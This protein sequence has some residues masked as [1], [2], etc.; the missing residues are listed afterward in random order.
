MTCSLTRYLLCVRCCVCDAA[1]AAARSGPLTPHGQAQSRTV[2]GAPIGRCMC[3]HA[4]RGVEKVGELSPA[5]RRVMP[6]VA[7]RALA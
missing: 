3:P 4:L 6:T 7:L 2:S 1:V 5:Q